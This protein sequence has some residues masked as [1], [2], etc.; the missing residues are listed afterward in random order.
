MKAL[1]PVLGNGRRKKGIIIAPDS[2]VERET[3][4]QTRVVCVWYLV[5]KREREREREREM[6]GLH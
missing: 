3:N 1:W 6:F 4:R 2:R 5:R